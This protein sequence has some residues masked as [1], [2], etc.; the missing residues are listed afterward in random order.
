[1]I[2]VITPSVRPEGLKLVEKALKRQTYTEFEWVICAPKKPEN[3]SIPFVFVQDPG[4]RPGTYWSIY[5][6]YNRLCQTAQHPLLVSW[7]DY[8]YTNPDTLERFWRHYQTEPDT[9][10]SAVGNKYSDDTFAVMT[11]KDPR[12]R[13]DITR[14]YECYPQDIEWNLSSVPKKAVFEV[15]GFDESLET[16]S[17]LC[18]LDVLIR[19]DI[20]KRWH[21]KL[22]QDIKSYSLE[23]GRLPE[24]DEHSPFAGIW[25]EKQR[26]YLDNPIL[27]YLP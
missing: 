15:G 27:H 1:M 8:T 18:G 16:H 6:S 25:Q 23:H 10:V 19:L 12:E 11:W 5:Q 14:F 3:I 13:N 24:W 17:S 9:L 20:T 22:N 26:E 21:F 4:K 7:Q 2:S